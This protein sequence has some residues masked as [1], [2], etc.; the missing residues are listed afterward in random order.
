MAHKSLSRK[1][2]NPNKPPEQKKFNKLAEPETKATEGPITAALIKIRD[3]KFTH[4]NQTVK[5]MKENPA[6]TDIKAKAD[7][8]E[9]LATDINELFGWIFPPREPMSFDQALE[10]A[11]D[12]RNLGMPADHVRWSFAAAQKRERGRPAVMRQASI[13]ALEIKQIQPSKSW[14]DIA[15]KLCPC[16]KDT[17]D[18][19]CREKLRQAVLDLKAFLTRYGI[20]VREV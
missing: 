11:Q 1:I 7:V 20:I 16:E 19:Q 15:T 9:K 18:F 6:A 5:S 2:E 14:M 12:M 3:E 4:L 10:F 17:H 8:C 13:R